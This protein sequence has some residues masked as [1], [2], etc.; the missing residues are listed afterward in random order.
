[1]KKLLLSIAAALTCLPV[2]AQWSSATV[3]GG[4]INSIHF[5]SATTGFAV[6]MGDSIMMTTNGGGT[7]SPVYSAGGYA[8]YSVH[9][10]DGVNIFVGGA[11]GSFFNSTDGGSTWAQQSTGQGYS[12]LSI[13][14]P[15]ANTGFAVGSTGMVIKTTNGGITWSPQTS[16]TS[17]SLY[18]VHFLDL[19]NG[20]AAGALGTILKT[21]D[22]G[23]T[24]SALATGSTA[25]LESV[26]FTDLNNG[27][28]VGSSGAILRTSDGGTT[29]TTPPSGT[30]NWL[31]GV[32]FPDMNTGYAVGAA[33][34]ILKTVDAGGT[35]FTQTSGTTNVLQTVYFVDANNGY[36]GGD[37]GLVLTAANGGCATPTITITGANT[38]CQG[39]NTTLNATGATTNWS[40]TPTT[41]LSSPNTAGTVAMPA[42][43]TTYTLSGYS[44]DG[45]LDTETI[46]I[47]VNALPS[48]ST[49]P[50]NA[51]CNGLCDGSITATGTSTS[52]T[53]Q[54][55]SLTGSFI[56]NLCAGT[57]TVTGVDGNGCY[58][59][60]STTVTQPS[61]LNAAIGSFTPALCVGVYDGTAL[62]GSSGGT[63]P[64]TYLWAPSGQTTSMAANLPPGS[65]TLAVTDA[66][67]CTGSTSMYLPATTSL[68]VVTS[69]PPTV[70]PGQA[71]QFTSTTTG[72]TPP[73]YPGWYDFV[74]S[75]IFSNADTAILVPM[76]SGPDSVK[77]YVSD[78]NGCQ[79]YD[80][81]VINVNPHDS[82]SGIV[83]DQL[84]NAVTSGEAY[85]FL[86]N[87]A[88]PGVLDTAGYSLISPSGNYTFASLNY[89][90]YYVKIIADTTVYPNSLATYYSNKTYPFQWDSALVINHTTCTGTIQGGY[91]V[92]ILEM[93]PLTG[94]GVIGGGVTEGPGFGQRYG[95]GAHA[96][97]GAPLKGVDV[98]LGKNPGGSP[99]ARTTT[100]ANGNYTF[101]NV[102]LNQSFRIY[103]DIPNFGMDSLYTVTLT[104]TDTVSLNNNYTVDSTMVRIDT[105]SS[106]GVVTIDESAIQLKVYPN[107]AT[108]H[109]YIQSC[110][111]SLELQ[112]TDVLGNI[113]WRQESF[114]G[115]R[116][117]GVHSLPSGLYFVRAKNGVSVVIKKIIIQH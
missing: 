88:N 90:S 23:A 8:L 21:T 66:N 93:T 3:G 96:P 19:S 92:T 18:G 20:F 116:L 46:T 14:F 28:A 97:L 10:P 44:S 31:Y 100:D 27:Y 40:W 9:S 15:D 109:L 89:G 42:S 108:S 47:T 49:A 62:D 4:T 53:W 79:G 36:A 38:I 76:V 68:T 34:T 107:P 37:N 82:L 104:S 58:N 112:L 12:L 61:P 56:T 81:L 30:T 29:W 13:F 24:W 86:Q 17:Q 63:P 16:G 103:V 60:M 55:G 73:Y 117:I 69:A 50:V 71:V 39:S 105:S 85:L 87:L 106:V 51:S 2:F 32:H 101:N 64:Y 114:H 67:G 74:T 98:K 115:Q 102:P 52:Y 95:N 35:W 7:W 45:C 94:P 33:G 83:T 91:N 11:S 41:G 78:A 113:V 26:Y 5:T 25:D 43:T 99:A 80:T 48:I 6:N 1:M 59:T 75:S 110:S 57:Y 54:P 72:G 77:F 22:G 70:C 84:S 65:L 111:N